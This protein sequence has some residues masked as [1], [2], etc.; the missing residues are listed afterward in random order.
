MAEEGGSGRGGLGAGGTAASPSGGCA[1]G[2]GFLLRDDQARV[3][4]EVVVAARKQEQPFVIEVEDASTTPVLGHNKYVDKF[5]EEHRLLDLPLQLSCLNGAKRAVRDLPVKYVPAQDPQ[6]Q[7]IHQHSGS[8]VNWF[9]RPYG[10]LYLV[11]CENLGDYKKNVRP[12][13]KELIDEGESQSRGKGGAFGGNRG[14]GAGSPSAGGD[15]ANALLAHTPWVVL[16]LQGAS[17]TPQSQQQHKKVFQMIKDDFNHTKYNNSQFYAQAGAAPSPAG[18][19]GLGLNRGGSGNLA[20]SLGLGNLGGSAAGGLKGKGD[21][22]CQLVISPD[23]NNVHGWDE[24]SRQLADCVK[25]SF[26][27]KLSAYHNE[28]HNLALLRRTPGWS[29]DH[30]FL[31]KGSLAHMFEQAQLYATRD[32]PITHTHTHTVPSLKPL[33]PS[34]AL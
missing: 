23:H 17:G 13:L 29:F 5:F 7:K 20:G 4:R 18:G 26:N 12:R 8:S 27:C 15:D 9:R 21:R 28:V 16:Y 11:T 31:V 19:L 14:N 33:P 32:P 3:R 1:A 25:F 34:F 2:A 24:L 30:F 22:V 10:R 6:L